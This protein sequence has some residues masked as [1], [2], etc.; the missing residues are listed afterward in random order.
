MTLA[1]DAALARDAALRLTLVGVVVELRV[2]LDVHRGAEGDLRHSA[3]QLRVDGQVSVLVNTAELL[4]N[5]Q[6][7]RVPHKGHLSLAGEFA[8]CKARSVCHVAV[9]E[10]T[11]MPTLGSLWGQAHTSSADALVWLVEMGLLTPRTELGHPYGPTESRA[12]NRSCLPA[13]NQ[14]L[15]WV[16]SWLVLEKAG[17]GSWTPSCAGYWLGEPEQVI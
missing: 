15:R 9:R 4:L 1:Q 10:T 14:H 5:E 3:L 6:L 16:G 11:L 7:V 8:P 17:D 13:A 12:R 2:G